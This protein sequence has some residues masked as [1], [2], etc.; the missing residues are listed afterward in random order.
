M[1]KSFNKK[2]PLNEATLLYRDTFSNTEQG[3]N[4]SGA[5]PQGAGISSKPK[6]TKHM[7]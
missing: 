1:E 7:E 3:A 4:N 2:P 6:E 5:P